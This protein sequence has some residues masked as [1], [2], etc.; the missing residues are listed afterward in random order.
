MIASFKSAALAATLALGAFV[1]VPAT[2]AQAGGSIGFGLTFDD[3]WRD[4]RD[5]R[6]DRRHYRPRRMRNRCRPRRALR[7]ARYLGLRRAY[8]HRAGP[9][10]VVVRGRARG[11]RL[12]VRFGRGRGC[13][14]RVVRVRGY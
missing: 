9:R 13:P 10:G 12:A 2:Q 3:G 1:A 6:R 4:A 5:F 7:K 14:V 11:Q 8:V